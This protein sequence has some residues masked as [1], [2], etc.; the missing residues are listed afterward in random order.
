METK[1]NNKNENKRRKFL[2]LGLL[3]GVSAV[4]GT[5]LI[6]NLSEETAQETKTGSGEM[7]KVLTPDGK[8]VEVP[9]ESLNHYPD[10]HISPKGIEK[11]NS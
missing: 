2:Q 6:S 10:A 7:T 1:K 5:S 3:S 9:A 8:L 11:R 4:A